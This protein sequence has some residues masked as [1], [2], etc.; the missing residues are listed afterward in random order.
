MMFH[1]LTSPMERNALLMYVALATPGNHVL[2]GYGRPGGGKTSMGRQVGAALGIAPERVIRWSLGQ[3]QPEAL[4]GLAVPNDAGTGLKFM[5]A[6]SLLNLNDGQPA[7]F[8][9]DELGD[10]IRSM[11]AAAHGALDERLF[12]D[13]HG[14]PSLKMLG[15]MNPPDYATDPQE[16][17]IG[18]SNRCSFFPWQSPSVD[19]FIAYRSRRGEPMPLTLPRFTRDDWQKARDYVDAVAAAYFKFDKHATLE[20]DPKTEQVRGRFPLAY[21]TPRSW[22]NALNL[23]AT[24]ICLGDRGA[25][26]VLMQGTIGE[27]QAL[28]FASYEADR[29]LVDGLA[30]LKKHDLFV[31]DPKR[32]DR[33]FAQVFAVVQ[34]AKAGVD[35]KERVERWGLAWS[36]IEY[37]R[38]LGGKKWS[39]IGKDVCIV[40]GRMLGEAMP[41]D[42]RGK[43]AAKYV[44][45]ADIIHE[46][47]PMVA[48]SAI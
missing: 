1:A 37:L 33:T 42:G 15:F 34:A 46:L 4:D 24:C 5:I 23:A 44:D 6:E 29:D 28:G 32:A 11:Q 14:K 10:C 20:E 43:P 8:I 41:L 16:Q 40:G 35:L 19:D 38:D 22:E 48:A 30:A 25:M 31:P 36:F 3:K 39:V 27:P 21:A 2:V 13:V 26:K 18:F 7:L 12:G 9:I 47:A 45:H 17:G